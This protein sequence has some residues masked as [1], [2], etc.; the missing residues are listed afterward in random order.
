MTTALNRFTRLASGDTSR[1]SENHFIYNELCLLGM[2][3]EI[4]GECFADCLINGSHHLAIAEFRL[5]LSFKLRF[6]SSVSSA[7][8]RPISPAG[9]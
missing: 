6:G 5:G 1:S 7:L 8:L 4:V 9:S 3:F 2:F